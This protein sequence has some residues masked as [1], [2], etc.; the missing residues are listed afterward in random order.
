MCR[1]LI[2][3]LRLI[4]VTRQ[5]NEQKN[6]DTH[7]LLRV[8]DFWR[9]NLTVAVG[10]EGGG[11]VRGHCS[12]THRDWDTHVIK[13]VCLLSSP[14][15]LCGEKSHLRSWV[16]Q[17]RSALVNT[18]PS[19]GE[20]E[21]GGRVLHSRPRSSF[22]GRVRQQHVIIGWPGAWCDLVGHP[23][24]P[25]SLCSLAHSLTHSAARHKEADRL[26][27]SLVV[28]ANRRFRWFSYC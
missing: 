3:S 20:G 21:E 10:G 23:S 28:G 15:L 18:S 22:R 26:S 1:G 2:S 5:P 6:T 8:S 13:P 4:H 14:A 12:N 27:R 17:W 25:P 7:T 24:I 16:S 11:G 19:G 9:C